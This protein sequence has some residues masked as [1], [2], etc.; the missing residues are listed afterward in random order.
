MSTFA[1][2]TERSI[3]ACTCGLRLC[4]T[5]VVDDDAPRFLALPSSVLMSARKRG[6]LTPEVMWK[7]CVPPTSALPTCLAL[8]SHVDGSTPSALNEETEL[9]LFD[10]AWDFS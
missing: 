1:S 6:T 8:V 2:F 5:P 10:W 3:V 4:G 9:L 7:V